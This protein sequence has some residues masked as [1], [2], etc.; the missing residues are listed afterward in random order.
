MQGQD[1]GLSSTGFGFA[2]LQTTLALVVVCA[3]A[4]LV[5]RLLRT[6]L[7]GATGPLR[8]VARLSLAPRHTL[9]VVEAAGKY[10]LLGAGDGSPSFLCELDSAR[11][12]EALAH[13]EKPL[14]SSVSEV[15]SAGTHDA[16]TATKPDM[17]SLVRRAL[18]GR[19]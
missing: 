3:L 19:S 16:A 15:A 13:A 4:A 5:L 8:V 14:A 11:V 12:D 1:A 10:L 2:L 6:R 18:G 17:L 7:A 9:Y